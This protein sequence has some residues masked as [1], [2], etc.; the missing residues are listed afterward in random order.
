MISCITSFSNCQVK[1][2]T[3]ADSEKREDSTYANRKKQILSG[4]VM[5]TYSYCGGAAPTEEMLAALAK[6]QPYVGKVFYVRKGNR[7]TLASEIVTRITTDSIGA[8]SVELAAGTWSLIQE[9]QV[10]EIDSN[11]Y[12]NTATHQV[13]MDCLRKWWSE[14]YEII[15]IKDSAITDLHFSFHRR[16]F[17]NSDIPCF[18][19]TG[20]Y[21]P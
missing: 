16:C 9:E 19:Y 12:K 13:D 3:M 21:P 2:H 4:K 5:I 20:P 18:N 15:E 14:P 7:N 11:N 17:I 8:F 10:K 6:P 1:K